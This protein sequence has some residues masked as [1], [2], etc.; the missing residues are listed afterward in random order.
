[1]CNQ[2]YHGAYIFAVSLME[3]YVIIMK[4]LLA[5]AVFLL[6]ALTDVLS[7]VFSPTKIHAQ[8]FVHIIF[9]F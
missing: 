1:M 5:W 3:H 4:N 2:G 9:C 7:S 6:T 8:S